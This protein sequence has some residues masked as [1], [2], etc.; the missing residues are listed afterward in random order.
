MKMEELAATDP[1]TGINNRR[2][3]FEIGEDEIRRARRSQRP[4]S[5]LMLD[6]NEFKQINDEYGHAAG[7]AALCQLTTILR[8]HL[9]KGEVVARLGGDEFAILLPETNLEEAARVIGRLQHRIQDTPVYIMDRSIILSLSAGA[10]QL[11][12]MDLALDDFLSRADISM[13]QVKK[14]TRTT[15][16]QAPTKNSKYTSPPW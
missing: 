11:Q 1:L 5:V 16:F 7:D 9:R 15:V 12:D 2:R 8:G 3:F 10:A 4:L 14:E 6:V 13:F